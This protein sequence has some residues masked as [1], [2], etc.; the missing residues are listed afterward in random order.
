LCT[1]RDKERRRLKGEVVPSKLK[2]EKRIEQGRSAQRK[3]EQVRVGTSPPIESTE[4][5]FQKRLKLSSKMATNLRYEDRLDGASNYVQWKYRMKNALQESKVWGIVEKKATIPTDAKDKELHHALEIRAQRILLDGVKDHLVP[6]IGE[7]QT[8]HEMWSHLKGLFEAKHESR[9]MALKERLQHTKMSKGEGV[10]VYLTKVKQ[11]L[12]EL[13]AVGVKLS[14]AEIVRSALRGFPKEWD[15]FIAGV[16]ARENL[17][18]WERLWNDCCQEEIRRGRNV[19]E[20]EEEENL[21]LTSKRGGRGR[22]GTTFRGGSTNERPKKDLSHVQCYVCGEFGHFASQCSQA[23]KG[24]GTKGKRKEV[25]ASAEIEDKDEEEEQQLAATAREFSRMFR[26]EYTLFLDAE[27]KTRTGWY[28][29]SGATSHM[30]GERLALQEFTTQDS[31]FV[32]CGVHSSMVAIQGKGTIS[33]QI[34][35]GRILRVPEVLYVPSMRVSVL[36]IS[37]L[38]HQGYGVSFF[39]CGVHIRSVR[40]QTPGPP[41]MIG[42]IMQWK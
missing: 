31:G 40:N 4:K 33:L 36:S 6:N 37:A 9:I 16:V 39:G 11:L 8:T 38:E 7:K 42:I 24:Y 29:D 2:Q 14:P 25:A 10:T 5:G 17:P 13:L 41:V 18:D 34:E 15:S 23:K 26:D 28:I 19:N 22:R 3:R 1:N 21:A 32:K 27:D 12:D 35:S 20:E 30:T